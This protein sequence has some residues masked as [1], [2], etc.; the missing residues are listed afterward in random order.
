MESPENKDI[1]QLENKERFR[2]NR[3]ITL[4]V[5][6]ILLNLTLVVSGV[7][8]SNELNIAYRELSNRSKYSYELLAENLSLTE[9]VNILEEKIREY[10][11]I[12]TIGQSEIDGAFEVDIG[13]LLK[14]TRSQDD[15][16]YSSFIDK[17][18]KVTGFV[19]TIHLTNA[20]ISLDD[21]N[22]KSIFGV[23]VLTNTENKDYI[24]SIIR[25]LKIGDKVIVEGTGG[26]TGFALAIKDTKNISIVNEGDNIENFK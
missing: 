1:E 6:S 9:K 10:Y 16:V 26:N 17:P 3:I 25:T 14:A 18:V 21:I 20:E 22:N 11:G 23:K 19:K 8:N 2:R 4:I 24:K 7:R 12:N 15:A 13:I 5:T